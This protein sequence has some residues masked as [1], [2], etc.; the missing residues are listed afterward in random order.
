MVVT[1]TAVADWLELKSSGGIAPSQNI[2]NRVSLGSSKSFEIVVSHLCGV[3]RDVCR[4]WK[5]Q[6]HLAG[7]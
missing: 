1:A 4:M 3:G 5:W 6:D 7:R 2:Q